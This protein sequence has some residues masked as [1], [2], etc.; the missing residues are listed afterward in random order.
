MDAE[1]ADKLEPTIKK[2]VADAGSTGVLVLESQE[3]K[4]TWEGMTSW[5]DTLKKFK[6]DGLYILNMDPGL[7]PEDDATIFFTSG[8]LFFM[9]VWDKSL[10]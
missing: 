2:L 8:N 5:D 7:T 6:N 4:G 9:F 10:H 1:R 3:G